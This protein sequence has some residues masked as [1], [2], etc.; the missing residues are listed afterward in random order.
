MNTK[1]IIISLCVAFFFSCE[2][3]EDF[4]SDF[5]YTSVYFAYQN[6]VR[7]VY[8]NNLEIEVGVVLGG[9]RMNDKDETVAYR[10][11]PEL[12]TNKSIVGNNNFI[13]LPT[14]YFTLSSPDQFI[15]PKGE[16]LGKTKLVLNADK[17]LN[18]P[19]ATSNTYAVPLLITTTSLD[20]IIVGENNA[21]RKDYS[22]VVIKYVH[23]LH[24]VYYH[25]GQRTKY[26]KNT[27][28]LIDVYRYV[29]EEQE[30]EFI[31]NI[32]WDM[33]TVD[34]Q[35]LRTNGVGEKTTSSDGKYAMEIT[36]DS[37]NNV[38]ITNTSQSLIDNIVDLGGSIYNSSKKAFYLNYEY[39]DDNH[40]YVMK[41][42]LYFRNN[43]LKLE[44]W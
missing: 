40:R 30:E 16:F 14:D 10:I 18:D 12:L 27:D 1:W 17:F 35:T 24:G 13:M 38:S 21:T 43:N 42:T 41:D 39:V 29:T 36:V 8:A 22:I 6:P 2:K 19:L 7:T 31:Q 33:F 25:R 3:Y 44:L 28:S 5:D 9:K 23:N 20:S 15:I 34:N 26:D 37:D 4:T 32:V 11:A